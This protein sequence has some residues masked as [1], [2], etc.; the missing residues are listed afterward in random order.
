MSPTPDDQELAK[1]EA[2]L[3]PA[4]RYVVKLLR[5]QLD[6]LKAILRARDE[7]NA[8]LVEQLDDLRR[9]L[10]GRRSE[11]LPPIRTAVRKLDED[12]ERTVEGAPM[13]E[14]EA[15]RAYERRRVA[16]KKSEPERKKKRVARKKSLPIVKERVEVAAAQIPEGMTREDFREVS[17]GD[18]VRRIEHVREHLLIKEFYLQTLVSKDNEVIVK[19]A[20]PLGVTE[21]GHYGASV[22]AHVITAKCAD[23]LPLHRIERKF[24]REGAPIARSTLCSLFHRAA[25]LLSPLHRR[26]LDEVARAPHVH[27]DETTFDI[28]QEGGCDKGWIWAALSKKAIAYVFD[29]SRSGE[30]ATRILGKSKGTLLVDGYSGY[31]DVTDDDGRERVACWGHTRRKFFEARK[32][33]PKAADEILLLITKL[34]RV[35]HQAAEAGV[36]GTEAHRLMRAQQSV[37]IVN[38]ID[39]W[40]DAHDGK[41]APKTKMGRAI[42][43]ANNQREELRRFLDDPTLPLDNNVAERALRIFALGRKNFL[44]AGHVEGAENLAVLQSLVATCQV[45]RVNPRE[46]LADVLLRIQTTAADEIDSLMPWNWRPPPESA[47]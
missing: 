34:Y 5:A 22:Y 20:P 42:T 36:L 27:A 21:G 10:F 37:E 13:P 15:A 46:Y 39:A 18:V 43:Y 8:L 17:D 9:R 32:A 11:K 38:A 40:V 14:D 26:L 7:T 29:E 47:A 45:H 33:S 1:L 25:R 16:R 41:Y 30:V 28:L 23:S 12:D 31:N 2:E 24:E 6:E 44:F 3:D 4:A 19:A 35:E